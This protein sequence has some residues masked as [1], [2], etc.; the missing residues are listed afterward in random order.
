M[1]TPQEAGELNGDA[2]K[3][4]QRIAE[5]AKSLKFAQCHTR[6][7]C[8]IGPMAV[9]A[10]MPVVTL[11]TPPLSPENVCTKCDNRRGA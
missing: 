7:P 5:Y 8:D 10:G 3:H 6:M 4:K 11:H 2:K 9:T 1:L